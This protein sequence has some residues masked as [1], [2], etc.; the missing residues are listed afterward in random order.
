MKKALVVFACALLASAGAAVGGLYLY[1]RERE[2]VIADGVTAAGVDLTG[3]TAAEARTALEREV[4]SRLGKPVTVELGKRGWLLSPREAGVKVDVDGM[5]ATA[6]KQSRSGTFFERSVRELT[7]GSLDVAIPL[8]ADYSKQ[9]VAEFVRGVGKNVF[10]RPRSAKISYKTTRVRLAPSRR[11]VVVRVGE[12]AKRLGAT[13][14]LPAAER[15]VEVPTDPIRPK[16]TTRD[17]RK[18]YRYFITVS[19]PE[20]KLRF[21]VDFKLAK[22]YRISI[23]QVG[24]ETPSGLYRIQNKAVNPTWFVP[25]RPWAGDLAGEVLPPGP[26]NPIK[27]RWMGIYDGAGIHGTDAVY[28]IG[29]SASHGCIR[30]LIPDVVELYERVPVQTPV[31]IA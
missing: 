26:D 4:G 6:L 12:L 15:V 10:R 16:V 20:F 2:N 21:F 31:L 1:D 18:K 11:G 17:L 30:M 14:T 29:R 24:F 7:G 8:R 5:V 27:A 28:S 25:N 22:V 9:A 13:L 3:L 23:G 19:R